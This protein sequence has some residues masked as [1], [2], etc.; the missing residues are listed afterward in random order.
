MRILALPYVCA[1]SDGISCQ[2]DVV[3]SEGH[4]RAVG[5]FP[6]FYNL[7]SKMTS[8]GEA[9]YKMT[10]LPATVFRI[11][12]RGFIRKNYVADLVVFDADKLDSKADFGTENLMPSGI[13]RV[14]VGGKTAWSASEP[15]KIGR[16]GCFIAVN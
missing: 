5:T 14:M 3:G 11:P 7:V 8:V 16:F 4:P 2:L 10:G 6:K 15:E 13:D 12:E 1:G 9:V